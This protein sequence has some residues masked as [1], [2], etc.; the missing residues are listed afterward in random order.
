MTDTNTHAHRN[1][2]HL[3]GL[4]AKDP[5]IRYTASGKAVAS[6]TVATKYQQSTEYHRVTCWEVLAEKAGKLTKGEFVKIVG[7]LQTR[8]WEDANQVK[9]YSTEIVAWQLVIPEKEPATI[10]TTGAAITDEDLPF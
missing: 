8:G 3:A 1:E 7:R 5:V 9:K 4:L 6:L 2:V 10:S